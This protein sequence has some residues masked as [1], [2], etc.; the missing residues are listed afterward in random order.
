MIERWVYRT[1]HSYDPSQHYSRKTF[2]RYY[3][4][5]FGGVMFVD[6]FLGVLLSR[7]LS[8]ERIPPGVAVAVGV[9]FFVFGYAIRLYAIQYLQSGFSVILRIE[10]GQQLVCSGPYKYVR[11]PS[12]SG[13]LLAVIGV[14]ISSGYPPVMLLVALSTLFL[15]LKR[16][17]SEEAILCAGFPEYEKYCH[18]TKKLIPFV[19]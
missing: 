16:I 12:Y 11:H 9:L 10:K 1:H 3:F 19:L 15:Q 4:W 7:F 13:G 8:I 17:R 14:G 6:F 2:D 5:I 18:N